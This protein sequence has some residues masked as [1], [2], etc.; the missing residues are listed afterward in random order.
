M[1]QSLP[2]PT[3]LTPATPSNLLIQSKDLRQ[4]HLPTS[5]DLVNNQINQTQIKNSFKIDSQTTLSSSA[6]TRN[7]PLQAWSPTVEQHSTQF[8]YDQLASDSNSWD[9]FAT[10]DRITGTK[11][12]YHEDIYTTKLDRSGP[13]FRARESR[14]AQLE[15]EILNV[16]SHARSFLCGSL[17]PFDRQGNGLKHNVHM[18]EERNL[19]DD[20]GLDEEDRQVHQVLSSPVV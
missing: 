7:K 14:A 18:V 11:T 6:G 12:N 15:K 9:Q 8:Q 10:N 19:V 13:D 20:T 4:V 1:L 5:I 17:T 2:Y 3:S 16:S